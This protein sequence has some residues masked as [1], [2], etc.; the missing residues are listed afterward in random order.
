M[1]TFDANT[2]IYY[3]KDDPEVVPV[4]Q[5]FLSLKTPI[6]VSTI[7][8][9]ELFGYKG[10]TEEEAGKIELILQTLSI[11]SLDSY[12]ARKAGA[13]RRAYNLKTPDSVIAATALFTGSTLVTRNIRDFKKIP[14]LKLQAI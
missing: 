13:L 4:V 7:I 1:Y 3:V 8:E 9:V 5:R 11:I 14:E 6:Y 10:L 2:I 12:L